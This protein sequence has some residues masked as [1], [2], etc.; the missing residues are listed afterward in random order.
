[1]RAPRPEE[2][3]RRRAAPGAG[4]RWHESTRDHYPRR[5]QGPP[6]PGPGVVG[7]ALRCLGQASRG[8]EMAQRADGGP[9]AQS[10]AVEE[11][12]ACYEPMKIAQVIRASHQVRKLSPPVPEPSANRQVLTLP[13]PALI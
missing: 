12:V 3:R 11:A 4:L 2:V 10:C 6:A 7:A 1:R 9:A 13:T 8:R 5:L